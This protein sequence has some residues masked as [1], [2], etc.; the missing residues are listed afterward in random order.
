MP[1]NRMP[2]PC[3]MPQPILSFYDLSQHVTA[4]STTRHGGFSHGAYGEFNINMYCGDDKQ[5]VSRNLEAL[6]RTLG[7][8][9]DAIIMPHQT[10]GNEVRQI[11]KDFLSLPETVKSMVLEGVD[12]LI[13]D[14]RNI[15]IGVSTADCIPIIIYDPEHNA[16]AA[17]HAG[18]RSTVQFIVQK[19]VSAMH[20]A[21]GSHPDK[22]LAAIGPGISL[23]A[24]E[25]GDEVYDEFSA[26][27]F[28]MEA[29]SLRKEKWHIDLKECNRRQLVAS[30]LQPENITVSPVCT[31]SCNSN[32]FSARRLGTASGRIYTGIMLK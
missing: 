20:I 26:A 15:C 27:G 28:D 13:T 14:V 23:D 24:F 9:A 7:I 3:I 22:L 5:C 16:S 19:A 32:Y 1:V 4:F 10:H 6:G 2:T 11:A 31:F 29:I 25:V 12:A 30:G 8:S 21:Y 18:W 17:V